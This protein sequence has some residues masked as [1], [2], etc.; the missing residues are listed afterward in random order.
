MGAQDICRDK[1]SSYDIRPEDE[2]LFQAAKDLGAWLSR[3]HEATEENRTAVARIRELLNNLPSVPLRDLHGD[4]GFLIM[5][6]SEEH[7]WGHSGSWSVGVCRGMLEIYSC[8]REDLAEF[9]WELCPG[10]NNCNDLSNAS[11]WIKQVSSPR[12][13]LIPNHHIEI[14]ASTWDVVDVETTV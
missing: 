14:D 2:V 13:L 12:A 10:W 11:E 6:N 8:G 3:Q 5:P 1:S 9:A 7:G 4:F